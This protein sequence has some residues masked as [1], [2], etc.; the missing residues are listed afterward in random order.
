MSNTSFQQWYIDK[1]S[2]DIP[3]NVRHLSNSK[4]KSGFELNNL[5]FWGNTNSE[6]N[7][8][9]SESNGLISGIQSVSTFRERYK[10]FLTIFSFSIIFYI[11]AFTIGLSYVIDISFVRYF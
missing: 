7:S 8:G 11:I 6:S 4:R 10:W 2:S 3:T 1:K 9:I 5:K